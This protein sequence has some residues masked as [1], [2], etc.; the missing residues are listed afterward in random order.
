MG[1]PYKAKSRKKTAP[2]P[3]PVEQKLVAPVG[4]IGAVLA[5]VGEDKERAEVALEQEKGED[6]PR[7]SLI[8]QL[9]E[10][11]DR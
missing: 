9:E 11:L 10:V 3:E 5:W 6:K 1:N 7:K 8:A 2:A 4:T